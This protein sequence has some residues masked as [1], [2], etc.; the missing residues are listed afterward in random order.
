MHIKWNC[1]YA[2]GLSKYRRM[3]FFFLKH[4]LSFQRY[5]H[6]SIMQIRS[7]K[8][9]YCLQLQSGKYWVNETSRNIEAVFFKLGTTNVHQKWKKMT[10]SHSN[11]F[12]SS[13]F[14]SKTS[15]SPFATFKVRQ[16]VLLGTDIVP[17]LS[18]LSL[19]DWV[20]Y[21]VFVFRQNWE[22]WFLLTQHLH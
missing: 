1:A 20:G 21:M 12:G 13:L 6:F 15:I 16:R 10:P 9:S 3:A 8:T 19:L 14:L 4:L 7:V 11:Y 5:W 18:S 2:K 22:F 17:I